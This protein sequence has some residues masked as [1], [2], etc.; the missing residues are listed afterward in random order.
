VLEVFL[1]ER[2][3]GEL[4]LHEHEEHGWFTAGELSALDWPDAD[5]PILPAL[6]RALEGSGA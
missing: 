2:R 6:A 1:A 5:L 3:S 4:R